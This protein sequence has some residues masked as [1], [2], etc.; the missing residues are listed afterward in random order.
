MSFHTII[1]P[2]LNELY[3]TRIT[4]RELH[5]GELLH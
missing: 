3:D 5:Y 4:I 1:L 2:F